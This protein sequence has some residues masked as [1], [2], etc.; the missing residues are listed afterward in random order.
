MNPVLVDINDRGSYLAGLD[1]ASDEQDNWLWVKASSKV[2][3][4]PIQQ[5]QYG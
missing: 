3:S 1:E 2:S 5:Q 4:K